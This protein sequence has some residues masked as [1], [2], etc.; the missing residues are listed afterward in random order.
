MAAQPGPLDPG[1]VKRGSARPSDPQA[2]VDAPLEPEPV[3]VTSDLPVRQ[4]TPLSALPMPPRPIPPAAINR[5]PMTA[6]LPL[7][8]SEGLRIM[9]HYT[10]RPVQDLLTDG[11]VKALDEWN[12]DWRSMVPVE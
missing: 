2:A 12:P 9:A 6:R 10:R 5:K 3:Q 7:K 11:A 4:E 1:L 8:V